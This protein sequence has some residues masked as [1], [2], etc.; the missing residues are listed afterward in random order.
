VQLALTLDKSVKQVH[1]LSEPAMAFPWIFQMRQFLLLAASAAALLSACSPSSPKPTVAAPNAALGAFGIDT[2][3]MDA[4]VKPGDD[5]F[6]YVNGTW[7]KT[8]ELPADKARFGAFDQ[9]AEKSES[10]VRAIVE[11]LK[12][13][14]PAAG[15]VQQKVS[16]LYSGFMDEA[17][18]EARGLEPLQP[19]LAEIDAATS[20][21]DILRLMARPDYSAPFGWGIEA[22]PSDPTRYA[23]WIGQA[24]LGMPNRDYYTNSG[25]RFDQY[26]TAYQGYLQRLFELMGDANPAA[27]A[28]AVYDLEA[29]LAAVHWTPEE[30]RDISKVVNPM[31]VAALAKLVPNVDWTTMFAEAGIQNVKDVVVG[32]TTAIRDGAKMLDTAPL[33]AWKKYLAAHLASDYASHL[34]KSFDE[35][36]FAFYGQ[37]LRGVPQ[38]RERWKRAISLLEQTIGEGVGEVYVARNFPADRKAKMD[39][40][41]ANLR[42][43]L[44]SRL[45]TLAWMDDATRAEALKKLSTFEPR[46]GYPAKWRDY[47]AMT[48][49]PGKHFENVRAAREFEWKRRL[50]RLDKPVDRSEWEMNPQ[51][52]NAYY[53][54]LM[55]QITFPAGILQPP[56]FD[57]AADP[58]VNYGAIGA[59]IGHEIGHGFDDQGRQ[60]DETGKIRNWWTEETNAKF[61]EATTRLAAQYN[62]YCPLEGVCVN[63]NLTMGENIG[64]LG[65]LQMAYTA[66]KMSLNGAE[67]PVID[68]YTGDQ[69]FFM[70]WAQVWRAQQRDDAA[71]Q[72]V[73]TDPHSPAKYRVN[74]V[75]RNM[76]AWYEAFGVKEGDAMYLPPD[77]R[78]RIW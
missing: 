27:S 60:F 62:T 70:A 76:D 55:N 69:R 3:Q 31:D 13:S 39:E 15:A 9:L 66:Y 68:G 52:V 36:N 21:A 77:Q 19:L 56:F 57:A 72:Q 71:R 14:A 46:I 41:V 35:A 16:D 29:K 59:V 58:A 50:A 78:V 42:K 65:G 1:L 74:G 43:S 7:L 20:K 26:R 44:D 38:Q 32:E 28:K 51:T 24:G 30:Q 34:P 67:A 6:A 53:N 73:L 47:S 8:F 5:F 10:D 61:V 40:L 12:T 37:T 64:D 63:G 45:Q 48:I 54:P 17:A 25:E 23:V 33:A 49:T 22:H 75:V 4:A 18:L 2:A 11:E